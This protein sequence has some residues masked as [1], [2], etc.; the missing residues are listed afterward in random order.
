RA[1]EGPVPGV[2]NLRVEPQVLVPQLELN[3]DP[4]K[5]A[6][7]GLTP[8]AIMDAVTTLVNGT[9]VGEVHQQQKV[10]DVVVWGHPDVR[11]SWP[12]LRYLEIDLPGGQGTI[13]LESVA[14]ICLINAPN[15]IR[16]DKASRCIDVS[17][18]VVGGD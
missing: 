13:R 15:T 9:K 5:V 8:A 1:G 3:M 16:H 7:Y 11:K 14:D 6:A 18:N 10:F 2:V 12:D 4:Q 17:C